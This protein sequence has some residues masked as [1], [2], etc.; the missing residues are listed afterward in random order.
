MWLA[1][2]LAYDGL[3]NGVYAGGFAPAVAGLEYETAFR[4]PR[5]SRAALAAAQRG[6]RR[7]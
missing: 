3:C 1:G 5:V 4:V 2:W 6:P 7:V